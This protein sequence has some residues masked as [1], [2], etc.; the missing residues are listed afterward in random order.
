[1]ENN[2]KRMY[3]FDCCI[4][5]GLTALLISIIGFVL[6]SLGQVPSSGAVRIAI[7]ASGI[8]ALAF[9]LTGMTTVM[10]HLRQNSNELYSVESE[11]EGI[12]INTE[13]MEGEAV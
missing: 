5:A 13:K 1:M 7:I 8:L 6:F 10:S 4:L 3:C 11:I 9:A 2:T 12:R